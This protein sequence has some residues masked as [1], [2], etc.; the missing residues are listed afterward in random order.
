MKTLFMMAFMGLLVSFIPYPTAISKKEK[1]FAV[2]YFKKTRKR[3]LGDVKGLTDAQLNW[4]PADS[5]WSV[6][7]CIEHITIA[8]EQLFEWAMGT[9][10][11]PDSAEK[12]AQRR[13]SNDADIIP[14][15]TNRSFKAKAPENFKPTGRFGTTAQALDLYK[16]RRDNLISY[17]KK[18]DDALRTHFA[19]TPVG[20]LDT[21][22]ML[23]F[24]AAHSERHTLQIEEVMANPGF[25]R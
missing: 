12:I 13:F 3:L 23:I 5:V 7:N 22:Q 24:L 1:K 11:V 10:K 14:F 16:Q 9:L 6:A 2:D 17:M 15:L 20:L 25:P 19:A 21:Y 4:K 18:N 8:E